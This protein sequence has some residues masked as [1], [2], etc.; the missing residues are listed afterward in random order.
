MK[1]GTKKIKKEVFKEEP[2]KE[3]VK[4]L[5]KKREVKMGDDVETPMG[6]GLLTGVMY[7]N[8]G[9][10]VDE[11]AEWTVKKLVVSINGVGRTF[12]EKDVKAI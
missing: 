6:D 7:I 11:K 2:V 5:R 10:V 12:E 4:E 8:D 1:K 9:T 3:I